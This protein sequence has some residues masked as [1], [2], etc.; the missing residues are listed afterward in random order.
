MEL[1]EISYDENEREVQSE[2]KKGINE[3]VCQKQQKQVKSFDKPG[4]ARVRESKTG[5][6]KRQST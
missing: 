6:L 1:V 5:T 4:E 3:A 2:K